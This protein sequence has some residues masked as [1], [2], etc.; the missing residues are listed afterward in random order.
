MYDIYSKQFEMDVMF[1]LEKD[2]NKRSDQQKQE[3]MA[4]QNSI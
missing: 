4:M 2:C 3:Q 1:T